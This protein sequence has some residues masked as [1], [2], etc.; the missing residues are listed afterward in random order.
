VAAAAARP[1][2]G[3]RAA[4]GRPR[5]GAFKSRGARGRGRPN[6]AATLHRLAR[7][8]RQSA[9]P[10]TTVADRR[11][12]PFD[13]RLLP[14]LPS[15]GE[16]IILILTTSSSYSPPRPSRRPPGPPAIWPS[17]TAARPCRYRAEVGD[18]GQPVCK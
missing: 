11:R 2:L 6:P 1:C 10:P 7:A 5:L 3:V 17:R 4:Q 16:H 14:P 8:A 18:K 13:F 9:E 15:A 12:R